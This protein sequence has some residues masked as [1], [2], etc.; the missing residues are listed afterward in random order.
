MTSGPLYPYS[1]TSDYSATCFSEF[2]ESANVPKRLENIKRLIVYAYFLI[3]LCLPT[4]D[5]NLLAVKIKFLS[6]G[7]CRLD[8]MDGV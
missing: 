3:L 5:F 8:R 4:C 2:N 6:L 1:A 7:L